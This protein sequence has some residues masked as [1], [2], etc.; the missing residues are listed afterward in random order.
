MKHLIDPT[1][2]SVKEIDDILDLAFDIIDNK[3]YN[4][5]KD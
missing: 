2:L 3:L 4:S 5:C 1:D